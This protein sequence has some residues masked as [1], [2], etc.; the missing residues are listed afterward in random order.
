MNYFFMLQRREQILVVGAGVLVVVLALFTFVLDPI[1][2]RAENLDRR[3][4][5][6]DHQ[7]A[8]LQTLRT[9]Y[10]RQK[11]MIDRIDRRLRR[12]QRNFAIFSYLEQVA[13]RTGLQ[14]KIQSMNTIASPPGTEYKEESVEVR[15]EDV[16][17]N[18]LV[19]YL[20]RLER[21]PQV[22]RIRRL[23]INP[24]AGDR[25]MLSVRMRVSVFSLAEPAG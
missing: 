23:Q 20:H 5:T 7:L 9:E 3:L 11:R 24:K 21:S 2:A 1:L 18:E 17:L 19:Q 10:L 12:R 14:E 22:L 15:M 8:E 16:T 13:G 6:A 25:Q 4:A